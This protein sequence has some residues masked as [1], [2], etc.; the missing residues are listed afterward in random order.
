MDLYSM[1]CVVDQ[2]WKK[3]VFRNHSLIPS[4]HAAACCGLCVGMCWSLYKPLGRHGNESLHWR[5]NGRD[6]VSN[7]QPHD[8]LLNRLSRRRS[9]KISQLRVS[10]LCVGNS[11]GT[12]E[13]PTQMA[14]NAEN[15]SIWWRHHFMPYF[16]EGLCVLLLLVAYFF[17]W[18]DGL[19]P[20]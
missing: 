16:A 10:G 17:L 9:K 13:F 3:A 15:A 5:H 19:I 2:Y 4:H 11:P 6:S 18:Y 14:S 20:I 12:G 1:A 8:C 7:H